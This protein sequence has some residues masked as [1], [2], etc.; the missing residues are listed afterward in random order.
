METKLDIK[1][2]DFF[3]KLSSLSG[4]FIAIAGFMATFIYNDNQIK[5]QEQKTKS[6]IKAREVEMLEKCMKYVTSENPKEREFGY[7]VFSNMGYKELAVNLIDIKH[8][9]A[10]INVVNSIAQSSDKKLSNYASTILAK[11]SDDPKQKITQ[12]VNFFETGDINKFPGDSVILD[13]KYFKRADSLSKQLGIKSTLGHLVLYDSYVSSGMT[14][15]TNHI[16]KANT[17]LHGAPKDGI[18]EG[19]WLESYLEFRIEYLKPKLAQFPQALKRPQFLLE[20][21]KKGNFDLNNIDG[22]K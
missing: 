12:V 13:Q 1:K 16:A 22:R 14:M 20:Q 6:E 19:L 7:A 9:T 18:N 10:G 11:L 2:K 3:D 4:V 21:V 17:K 5:I 15:L 8:D